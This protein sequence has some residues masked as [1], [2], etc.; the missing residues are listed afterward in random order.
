M[1]LLERIRER[2][3][4]IDAANFA[5]PD[6]ADP[7]PPGEPRCS[8]NGRSDQPHASIAS[9]VKLPALGTDAGYLWGEVAPIYGRIVHEPH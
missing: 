5:L 7:V 1:P 6:G 8:W 3:K 4:L 2:A 9:R